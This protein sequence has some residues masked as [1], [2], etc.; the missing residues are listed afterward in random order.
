MSIVKKTLKLGLSQT[1]RNTY[2]LFAGNLTD[3]IFSFL[4][5]VICF[6][7]L[8]TSD[9]GIFSAISNFIVIMFSVS[10]VGISSGLVN[11]IPYYTSRH[12]ESLSHRFESVG[13]IMRSV[14][15]SV[16]AALVILFSPFISQAFFHT[17][18]YSSVAL[19]GFAVFGLSFVEVVYFA[20][21]ARHKFIFSAAAG[22]AYSS[23]R[24]ILLLPFVFGYQNFSLLFAVMITSA[25]SLISAAVAA[26]L[27]KIDYKKIVWDYSV[28]IK[29]LSFSGWMGITKIVSVV[30]TRIDV[31]LV[32]WFLG[33]TQAGIYSVASRLASF[34]YVISLSFNSVLAPRFSAGMPSGQ[35][36]SL[37]FKA[38]IVV[39]MFLLAMCLGIIISPLLIPLLFGQKAIPSIVIFQ[40]LTVA[41]MPFMIYSLTSS[42]VI[43]NFKKPKLI[44]LAS[45]L[46]LVFFLVGNLI[47]IPRF[48]LWGLIWSLGIS[49]LVI[50]IFSCVIV[51]SRL[52]PVF[53]KTT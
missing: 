16:L 41:F 15:S 6:R 27:E 38:L 53:S 19:A 20:L 13:I 36:K 3:A 8:S 10:D 52:Y 17:Q 37:L 11:F 28:A 21:Q 23:S 33:S 32:L 39:M 48:G 9:F 35:L 2:I 7:L 30:L 46:Q 51:F 29:M 12:Q 49:N 4:F 22:T 45:L 44:S 40:G 14:V 43:Y 26:Y 42:L 50:L 5:A 31:Q 18:S 24:L 25:S 1:A 34:Y 47:L